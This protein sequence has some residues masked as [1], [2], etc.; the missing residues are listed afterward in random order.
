MPHK[1]IVKILHQRGSVDNTRTYLFGEGITREQRDIYEKDSL[2][3][4]QISN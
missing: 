1:N 3:R 2:I 4:Q